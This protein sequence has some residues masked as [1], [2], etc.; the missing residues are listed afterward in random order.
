MRTPGSLI[1]RQWLASAICLP[2]L[3]TFSAFTLN[4]AFIRSLDS[5]ENDAL[6]AQVY[7]LIAL[8]EPS[9][10]KLFLPSY[11]SNPRLE[12]P[13]SGLYA[14]VIDEQGET[15]WRSNSLEASPIH[16][17]MLSNP[18][19]GSEKFRNIVGD[20]GRS[21]RALSFATIWEIDGLDRGFT[22][23]VFHSQENKKK[24]ILSYKK[25]LLFWLGG[26]AGL[27]V[28]IQITVAKW[29][30]K[31][32][33]TLA[34]EIEQ[35]ETGEKKDLEKSYPKEIDPV[36]KSLN[37]LLTSEDVQRNRYKNALA[38]LAHSL[39]TPLAVV[40][41]HLDDNEKDRSIDEQIELMSSI[42]SRQLRRANAEVKSIYGPQTN[43][44]DTARRL[45][46]ALNKVY[47]EKSMSLSQQVQADLQVQMQETD[48]MEVLGNIIENAFKYGKSKVLV[49]ST[50]TENSAVFSVE[51]DGPG[52]PNLLRD[53]ILERGARADTSKLG[54]GI[55]LAVAV[56]ILSSYNGGIEIMSSELGGAKFVLK[57]PLAENN[58]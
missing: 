48:L 44:S 42:I 27:L 22:F 13:E 15:S 17:A 40:R 28:I 58:T 30:L 5:A 10:T 46:A 26:M 50:H 11:L 20:E 2:I 19:P 56:D 25:A 55:G 45:C 31:P 23:E 1:R 3:V 51:D 33:K 24:E 9:E 57:L 4:R 14:R 47:Q 41:T 43:L 18:A 35:I 38:D 52:V 37:K 21:Y 8:A 32:L 29:G 6:L 53:S 49:K 12:T 36:T 39:K 16:F 7:S 54:Q 34:K